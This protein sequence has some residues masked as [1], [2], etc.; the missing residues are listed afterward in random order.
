MESDLWEIGLTFHFPNVQSKWVVVGRSGSGSLPTPGRYPLATSAIALHHTCLPGS[1]QLQTIHL[2]PGQLIG[3]F[4]PRKKGDSLAACD[5]V[6]LKGE[7]GMM[8]GVVAA[9]SCQGHF[10]P[11]RPI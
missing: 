10:T 2:R 8:L 1:D 6:A 11:L 4:H 7:G 3:R 9:Q 5:A